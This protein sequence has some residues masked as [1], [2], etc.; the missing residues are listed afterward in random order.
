MSQ[1]GVNIFEGN[2]EVKTKRKRTETQKQAERERSTRRNKMPKLVITFNG[3]KPLEDDGQAIIK[4][5]N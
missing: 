5:L 2:N 3:G 4:R 1:D